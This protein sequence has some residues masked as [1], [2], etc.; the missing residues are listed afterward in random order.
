MN[1]FLSRLNFRSDP[2][3]DNELLHD[4]VGFIP[5]NLQKL[6]FWIRYH[7]VPDFWPLLAQHPLIRLTRPFGEW[8]LGSI[9]VSQS[10]LWDEAA[11]SIIIEICR[12]G[13][14]E[15][16]SWT[17]TIIRRSCGVPGNV[18]TCAKQYR[19]PM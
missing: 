9:V 2:V 15:C 16:D 11:W 3:L 7:G 13:K 19:V 4:L 14:F 5:Q 8:Q 1:L 10:R 6:Q 18:C 12:I 17:C